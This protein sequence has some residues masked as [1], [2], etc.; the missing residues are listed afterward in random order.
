M[1]DKPKTKKSLIIFASLIG[2]SLLTTLVLLLLSTKD[3]SFYNKAMWAFAIFSLITVYFQMY[4]KEFQIGHENWMKI[5]FAFR[6]VWWFIFIMN[7]FNFA[8]QAWTTF[9]VG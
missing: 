5:P 9:I 6:A 4:Y 8:N 3:P 2:L 1:E 7:T